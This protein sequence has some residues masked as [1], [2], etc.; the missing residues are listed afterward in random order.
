MFIIYFRYIVISNNNI[1]FFF[2]YNIYIYIYIYILKFNIL[3]IE[4]II[5]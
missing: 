1:S 4:I 2:I 3:F 5:L